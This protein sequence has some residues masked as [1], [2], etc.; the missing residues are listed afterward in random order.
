MRRFF[1]HD[2]CQYGLDLLIAIN[3][4]RCHTGKLIRIQFDADII[5]AAILE[6][7]NDSQIA[8]VLILLGPCHD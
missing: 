1:Y 8:I 3:I 7:N 2:Q 5:P 6:P 4:G